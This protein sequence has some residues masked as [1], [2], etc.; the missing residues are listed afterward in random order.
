MSV[1]V[2]VRVCVYVCAHVCKSIN[3]YMRECV[4]VC[5]CVYIC[6]P[7]ILRGCDW[8][9]LNY[10]NE[11]ACLCACVCVYI[12]SYIYLLIYIK[13]LLCIILELWSNKGG[14]YLVLSVPIFAHRWHHYNNCLY[15]PSPLINL[16]KTFL[17]Y[18]TIWR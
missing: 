4:C 17:V 8:V 3:L 15:I 9:L 12:Y 14:H 16:I 10:M 7:I 6:I 11:L 5:V 13:C 2:C 18:F 1:Y